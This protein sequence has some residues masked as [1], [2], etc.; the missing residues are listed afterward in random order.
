MTVQVK[1]ILVPLDHSSGAEPVIEYACAIARG[2]NA[3]L[4][5]MH[6]FEPPNEMVGVVPGATVAEEVGAQRI[7]G[8]EVLDRA[9][10][11]CRANGVSTADRILERATPAHDAIVAHATQGKYD[12]V[13]MGTHART[14]VSRLVMG[15]TAEQVLRHSPCPILL[16]HLARS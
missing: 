11:L 10:E 14:G 2:M 8:G 13:V 9:L 12:L 3:A 4:T 16:V 6:V 15:S 1:R 5:L 7:A